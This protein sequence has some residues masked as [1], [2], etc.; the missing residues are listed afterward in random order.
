[1]TFS[2]SPRDIVFL[3]LNVNKELSW[4]NNFPKFTKLEIEIQ[5]DVCLFAQPTTFL[6]HHVTL[7][8]VRQCFDMLTIDIISQLIDQ[9]S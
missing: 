4:L 8:K 2:V 3:H 5:T 9:F 1:M 6:L 7:G